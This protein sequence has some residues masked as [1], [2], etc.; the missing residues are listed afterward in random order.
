MVCQ[1]LESM[2]EPSEKKSRRTHFRIFFFISTNSPNS[3]CISKNMPSRQFMD[4]S[5]ILFIVAPLDTHLRMKKIL[6]KPKNCIQVSPYKPHNR[7]AATKVK[8]SF[9]KSHSL[10]KLV[11]LPIGKVSE[12]TYFPSPPQTPNINNME[13]RYHLTPADNNN[14]DLISDSF[15]SMI[16]K[17]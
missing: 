12:S 13:F 9:R 1:K 10:P 15:G 17:L 14:N 11:S 2:D 5:D 7:K 4:M 6:N 3:I 8:K 16:G